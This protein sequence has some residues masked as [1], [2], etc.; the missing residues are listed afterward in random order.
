AGGA[1]V[2]GTGGR[3]DQE[4]CKSGSGESD[5]GTGQERAESAAN[6]SDAPTSGTARGGHAVGRRGE[7]YSLVEAKE[8]VCDYRCGR[9][10]CGRTGDSRQYLSKSCD[11]GADAHTGCQ[12]SE[13][14]GSQAVRQPNANGEGH[15]A[16]AGNS[17]G[18]SGAAARAG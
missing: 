4:A 2:F 5:A 9:A 13:A 14:G 16:N 11:R 3:G 8:P 7:R 6:S 15:G 1:G 18:G 17:A 10:D 12:C